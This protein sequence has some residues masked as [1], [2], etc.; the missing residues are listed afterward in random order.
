MQ[1]LDDLPTVTKSGFSWLSQIFLAAVVYIHFNVLPQMLLE[2]GLRILEIMTV[3][4][5]NARSHFMIVK[6]NWKFL[7]STSVILVLLP[8]CF[9][10]YCVL[11]CAEKKKWKWLLIYC[12]IVDDYP[13]QHVHS[14][15]ILMLTYAVAYDSFFV[16][17]SIKEK[18]KCIYA[19]SS[20]NSQYISVGLSVSQKRNLFCWKIR[21][22]NE[23]NAVLCSGGSD[24]VPIFR[25]LNLLNRLSK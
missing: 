1:C 23:I 21:T 17:N 3:D 13:L 2:S 11:F 9:S 25:L 15:W 5:C 8:F 24:S 22:Q 18:L 12:I 19:R 16:Q 7:T 14:S 10:N 6:V 4:F 20:F